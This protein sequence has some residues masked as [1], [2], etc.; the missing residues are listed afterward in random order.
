MSSEG[1]EAPVSAARPPG[2]RRLDRGVV[3]VWRITG[4]GG[5]LVALAGVMAVRVLL[6]GAPPSVALLSLI[7]LFGSGAVWVGAALRY[8]AW[9]YQFHEGEMRVRR[10]VIA[11]T[12]S[13]IPLGRIQHVDTRQNL[14]ERWLGLARIVIYTAGIRGAE[15]TIPGVPEGEAEALRDRLATFAGA[16]RAV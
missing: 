1:V 13:V 9:S 5:I 12:T 7:A 11:R 3:T 2:S 16:D 14:T 10:G 4:V 8:G 15:I 6:L